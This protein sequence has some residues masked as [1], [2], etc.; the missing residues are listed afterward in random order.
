MLLI[1]NGYRISQGAHVFELIRGYRVPLGRVSMP[2]L[3]VLR[4]KD[5]NKRENNNIPRNKNRDFEYV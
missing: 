1:D 4:T 5:S 3:C 2:V